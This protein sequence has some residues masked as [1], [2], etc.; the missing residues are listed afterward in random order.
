MRIGILV[1]VGVVVWRSRPARQPRA[2]TTASPT[3]AL[4]RPHQWWSTATA[5]P[6]T[7][8]TNNAP[9]M[10]D[11]VGKP[12]SACGAPCD[13]P[14]DG[15]EDYIYVCRQHTMTSLGESGY[16]AIYLTANALVDFSDGATISWRQDMSRG[17]TRHWTDLSITP[18][19]DYLALPVGPRVEGVDLQG[20]PCNA[21]RVEQDAPRQRTKTRWHT[22][23]SATQHRSR[24]RQGEEFPRRRAAGNLRGGGRQGEGRQHLRAGRRAY[25]RHGDNRTDINADAKPCSL[26]VCPPLPHKQEKAG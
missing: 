5:S 6:P 26:T 11:A 8:C 21:I 2:P 14:V 4:T 16:G 15:P 22:R 23:E 24:L 25:R 19:E 13:A 18:L 17:S 12:G 1:A 20:S 7:T 9:A 3:T 10:T